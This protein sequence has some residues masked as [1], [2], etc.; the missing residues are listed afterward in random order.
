MA[1]APY[2]AGNTSA[3]R[4]AGD[5][6]QDRGDRQRD[7]RV[8]PHRAGGERA[9]VRP[10]DS[11][12]KNAVATAPADE[13]RDPGQRRAGLVARGQRAVAGQHGDQHHVQRDEQR[14]HALRPG[15]ARPPGAT[16]PGSATAASHAA[17]RWPVPRRA[18]PP[19][20][21]DDPADPERRQR[22]GFA[23]PGQHD[24]QRPRRRSSARFPRRTAPRGQR[25]RSLPCSQPVV[26]V[27]RKMTNVL[28][29]SASAVADPANRS[30]D[31]ADDGGRDDPAPDA[32][33]LG[34]P[35]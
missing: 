24:Q 22:A 21:H 2:W 25:M 30:R 13:Q 16:G 8:H 33:Q 26:V 10:R 34:E 11:D 1:T 6:D 3:R 4:C 15:D 28:R 14:D 5:R 27:P 18:R 23:Q 12:G 9:T 7:R 32:D 29:A 31:G 17:A 35:E 20:Q 19:R